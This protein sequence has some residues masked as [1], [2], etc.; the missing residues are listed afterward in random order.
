MSLQ[1]IFT[2]EIARNQER[3]N[4]YVRLKTEGRGLAVDK[5]IDLYRSRIDQLE[6]DADKA[7]KKEAKR[8][9]QMAL[10][11]ER[12]AEQSA[13]AAIEAEKN[14][15]RKVA[16]PKILKAKSA[17]SKTASKQKRASSKKRRLH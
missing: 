8:L 13:A 11:A 3:L 12:A 16:K 10:D 7:A 5:W 9:A 15:G 4:Y 1:P 17:K 14:R 2:A 6:K